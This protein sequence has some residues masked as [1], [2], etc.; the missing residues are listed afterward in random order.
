MKKIEPNIP[1]NMNRLETFARANVRLRKKRIGSIGCS[2]RCSQATKDTS[3]ATPTTN[4][5]TIRGEVQPSS[6]ARTSPHTIPSR[7]RLPRATPTRS[8]L[9]AGPRSEEHTSELQ[10]RQYLVCRLLLEKK[11]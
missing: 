9:D 8:S 6:S 7:P 4:E 2:A 11:K 1:K 5:A 3:S 10:S